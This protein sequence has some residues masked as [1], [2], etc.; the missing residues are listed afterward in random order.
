MQTLVMINKLNA[1]EPTI[2]A[3]PNFPDSKLCATVSTI[4]SK[5][6]G[7]AVPNAINIK[8]ATVSFHTRTSITS[9]S[10]SFKTD[11]SESLLPSN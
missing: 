4:D 8:F 2:V 9:G 6:S 7:D 1:A 3:G 10:S 11:S 5:I